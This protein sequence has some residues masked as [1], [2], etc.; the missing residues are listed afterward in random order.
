MLSSTI[1]FVFCLGGLFWADYL[2]ARFP[3]S[4]KDKQQL[5]DL[6]KLKLPS[7]GDFVAARE[8][9]MRAKE[10]LEESKNK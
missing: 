3:P 7:R 8:Q 1:F 6:K 9:A 5:E 4:E 10:S 2:E